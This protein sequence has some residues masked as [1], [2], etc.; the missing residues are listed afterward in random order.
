MDSVRQLYN[1]SQ[2][3]SIFISSRAPL[4]SM[5]S[6]HVCLPGLHVSGE[7]NEARVCH[8]SLGAPENVI[9]LLVHAWEQIDVWAHVGTQ[10]DHL[11]E[12]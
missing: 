9:V 5:C 10:L 8:H 2:L 11:G 3:C 7:W 6:E 12:L 1:H 4:S